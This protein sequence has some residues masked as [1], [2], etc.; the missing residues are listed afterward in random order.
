[1]GSKVGNLFFA[2]V[3]P[4]VKEIG[5]LFTRLEENRGE[6]SSRQVLYNMP[7]PPK[8]DPARVCFWLPEWCPIRWKPKLFSPMSLPRKILIFLFKFTFL[9]HSWTVWVWEGVD[10]W[11]IKFQPF[12]QR[13]RPQGLTSRRHK[14]NPERFPLSMIY[15]HRLVNPWVVTVYSKWKLSLIS[16]VQSLCPQICPH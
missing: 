1:M 11:V 14:G 8:F 9:F 10:G 5:R 16:K 6:V 2:M 15:A 4:V 3:P 12:L 7:T 13:F